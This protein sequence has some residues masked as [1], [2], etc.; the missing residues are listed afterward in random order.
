MKDFLSGLC[1]LNDIELLIVLNIFKSLFRF[2]ESQSLSKYSSLVQD[3]NSLEDSLIKLSD[4][5]LYSKTEAFYDR[6]SKGETLDSLLVECFAVVRESAKR[7]LGQR[8][9][10]TQLM[11][12]I[13]LHQGKIA[14]MKTGEGKTLVSTLAVYLNAIKREGVHVVTVNDYLARRDTVWMGPIYS[15]LGLTVG[16]LQHDSA[17]I[18]KLE[19]DKQDITSHLQAVSRNEAYLADIIYGTNNEFGFDYLRD[20]MAIDS[21]NQVQRN[22]GYAIVDEVDNI[23]I[24]ESRTPLIISGPSENSPQIYRQFSSL[25]RKLN[26]EKD[27]VI[28]EKTRNAMLTQDGITILE[29]SL[30]VSNLYG[31]DNYHYIPLIDNAL[32]ANFVY[33]RDKDYV[34]KDGEVVIVDEF[35]G[36]LQI[37]RRYSDGLHQAIEA[38]EA[39]TIQKESITYATITLQNYFRMYKKLAGMTGTAKTEQEEFSKIYNLEV[40]VIPTNKPMAR[41]DKS[42]LI[43][44]TDVG[45]WKAIVE[46]ISL[47]YEKERPTLVGTTSIENSEKL[48]RFLKKKNIKHQILNAK[49]HEHEAQ[50]IAQAGRLNAITV[51]TNMAGRGTDIVL[52]G[53]IDAL[54]ISENDWEKE[55]KRV[56][57]L[58]GLYV[59]GTEHHD[60]RRI[61]NQLRGR[62]GRQGDPGSSRFYVSLED[63]LMKRFGADKVKNLLLRFSEESMPIEHTIV[64]KSI[65]NAQVKV[66]AFHFDIRKHLLDF[67]DV[68]SQQRDLIYKERDRALSD[69]LREQIIHFTVT[70]IE[71]VVSN[72]QDKDMANNEDNII[73]LTEQIKQIVPINNKVFKNDQKFTSK[74]FDNLLEDLKNEANIVYDKKEEEIGLDNMRI[75]EKT[76]MLKT[77]DG[78]WLNHLTSMEQLRQGVGLHAYGQRD[79]L[80]VYKAEGHKMFEDLISVIQ[81]QV[82]RLI[83]NLDVGSLSGFEINK[84]NSKKSL[85]TVKPQETN[86]SNMSHSKIGRNDLCPC[87]NGKKYKRCHGI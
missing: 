62:S 34:V 66:E 39:V 8:H 36:R 49:N 1:F 23:L 83:F 80:V 67:D 18:Y 20:N 42:D 40:V 55:H 24:D 79:P 87:G 75:L 57:E 31:P 4:L 58:G 72:F 47:Q 61:D 26:Q 52:G 38:K 19:G 84:S 43:Y 9:F 13:A 32:K 64:T 35:T 27:Y 63:E 21:N 68:L 7:N 28:D 78:N 15:K 5:E 86:S 46:D 30:K 48:S 65:A 16:C 17:Y 41:D 53:N 76:I 81:N 56:I 73:D 12:G 33:K 74:F 45:K 22:L 2:G 59:I 6:I 50:I 29:K 71:R 25:I 11:G 85:N 51:A 14:E 69:N 10:D 82:S 54:D 60:A 70:E 77:I 3:I 44:A 37:G